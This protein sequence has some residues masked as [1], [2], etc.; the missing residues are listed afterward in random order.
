M[1]SGKKRSGAPAP[2]VFISFADVAGG[3]SSPSSTSSSLAASSSDATTAEGAS[4]TAPPGG[5]SGSE[6]VVLDV[7]YYAGSNAEVAQ[8]TRTVLKKDGVTRVKALQELR[9]IVEVNTARRS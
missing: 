9:G 6:D 5:S 2:G 8:L 4:S 1:S 7:A 3:F